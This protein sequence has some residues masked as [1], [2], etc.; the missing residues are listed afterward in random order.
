MILK[1]DGVSVLLQGKQKQR[2]FKNRG[3]RRIR[4][5]KKNGLLGRGEY[6]KNRVLNRIDYW[7]EVVAEENRALNRID[8]WGEVVAEENR[9]LNRIDYWGEVVAEENM[10]VTSYFTRRRKFQLLEELTVHFCLFKQFTCYKKFYESSKQQTLRT[11]R[12]LEA[13]CATLWW[14]RQLL[15]LCVL[16]QVMEHRWNE[17]DRE[18][19]KYSEKNLSQCHFVHHKSHMDWPGIEPGPPRWE[20]ASNRLSHDT[21]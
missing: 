8:Y 4:R 13:S 9:V 3:L 17:I 10:V 21:A 6:W 18:K 16:F 5:W 19:P 20:P 12:S 11:H 14:R 15:L 1:I 7:G 2:M